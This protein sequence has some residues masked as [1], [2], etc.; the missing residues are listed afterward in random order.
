[1]IEEEI[2]GIAGFEPTTPCS[3]SRCSTKLSYIPNRV[4]K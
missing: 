4:I 3:Q 1:L 2:F